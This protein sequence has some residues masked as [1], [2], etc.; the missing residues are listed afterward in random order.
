MTATMGVPVVRKKQGMDAAAVRSLA[1]CTVL[2]HLDR[3][4]FLIFNAFKNQI[5]KNKS[6]QIDQ[7]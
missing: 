4:T 6:N 2:T 7:E 5:N 1:L 3:W